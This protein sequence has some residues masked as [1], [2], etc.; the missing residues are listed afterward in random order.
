MLTRF[1]ELTDSLEKKRAEKNFYCSLAMS[2]AGALAPA[3]YAKIVSQVTAEYKFRPD[4]GMGAEECTNEWQELGC[5]LSDGTHLLLEM[6]LDQLRCVVHR[7]IKALSRQDCLALW[8]HYGEETQDFVN[9]AESGESFDLTDDSD[10]FDRIIENIVSSLT[11]TM[12]HDWEYKLANMENNSEDDEIAEFE[13]ELNAL[14]LETDIEMYRA[15]LSDIAG[16]VEIAGLSEEMDGILN[17]MTGLMVEAERKDD[18]SIMNQVINEPCEKAIVP[19]ATNS[20][21]ESQGNPLKEAFKFE[22]KALESAI[23]IETLD[24]QLDDVMERLDKAGLSDS[25]DKELND[26]VDRMTELLAGTR[27]I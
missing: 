20:I 6:G 17:E 10:N 24:K 18:S 21:T 26:A 13:A 16:R 4:S 22:L 23:D 25:L 1:M 15:K 11:T 5:M 12:V 19:S 14:K 3:V 8:C 7:S 2:M 9:D 27:R